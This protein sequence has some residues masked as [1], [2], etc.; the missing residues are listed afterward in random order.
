MIAE[1]D[2]PTR[3]IA[4]YVCSL[5]DGS[6]PERSMR[7]TARHLVD[8]V[9]CALGALD[10]RPAPSGRGNRCVLRRRFGA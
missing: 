9:A 8:S 6:I 1:M 10:S 4:E 3:A 5:E 2:G 7:D